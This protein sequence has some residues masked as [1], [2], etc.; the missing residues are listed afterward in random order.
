M[1]YILDEDEPIYFLIVP[2]Q[3][4]WQWRFVIEYAEEL[5]STGKNVVVISLDILNL[6]FIKRR[7]FRLVGYQPVNPEITKGLENSG[8]TVL[9]PNPL[10]NWIKTNFRRSPVLTETIEIKIT[11]SHLADRT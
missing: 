11:L 5:R 10:R 3:D 6:N 1:N 9:Q 2:Y 8:I 4:Q 7:I